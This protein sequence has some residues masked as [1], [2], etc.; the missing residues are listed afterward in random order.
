MLFLG[1]EALFISKLCEVSLF[2][3]GSPGKMPWYTRAHLVQSLLDGCYFLRCPYLF[4]DD[5][6]RCHDTHSHILFNVLYVGV[7][8][9]MF[10]QTHYWKQ[11]VP[12]F[13]QIALTK[14]NLQSVLIGYELMNRP[15][16]IRSVTCVCLFIYELCDQTLVAVCV[17]SQSL[18]HNW[19]H[20]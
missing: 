13:S 19:A 20:D 14:I 12:L 5:L 7:W 3:S 11:C 4:W 2:I 10:S 16:A 6:V 17:N 9:I 15:C 1:H 8:S 18:I